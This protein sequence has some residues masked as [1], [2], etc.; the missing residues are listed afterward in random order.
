MPDVTQEG[1]VVRLDLGSVDFPGR[2]FNFYAILFP[3]CWDLA[4]HLDRPSCGHGCAFPASEGSW[5]IAPARADACSAPW[6]GQGRR[7][8]PCGEALGRLSTGRGRSCRNEGWRRCP[9]PS[10]RAYAGGLEYEDAPGS[11][12]DGARSRWGTWEAGI[13]PPCGAGRWA[14]GRREQDGLKV[15]GYTPD[16]KQMLRQV[17]RAGG[18][19]V[20]SS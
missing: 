6:A 16:R 15:C 19:C 17:S 12:E 8:G 1:E 14:S 3:K 7:A 5:E 13:W 2:A 9:H 4:C 20:K 10:R 11:L 18:P